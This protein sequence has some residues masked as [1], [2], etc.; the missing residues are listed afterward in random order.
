M[1]LLL[2][3]LLA[4]NAAYQRTGFL[5]AVYDVDSG[6]LKMMAEPALADTQPG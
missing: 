6:T 4:A 5:T 1:N 2:P 3:E